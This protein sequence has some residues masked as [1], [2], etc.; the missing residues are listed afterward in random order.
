MTSEWKKLW[1]EQPTMTIPINGFHEVN[2]YYLDWALK[3]L[4]EGDKLDQQVN[5][6]ASSFIKSEEARLKAVNDLE[7]IKTGLREL[8]EYNYMDLCRTDV[9]RLIESES[10][11]AFRAAKEQAEYTI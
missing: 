1:S 5:I 8:L 6:L 3:V 10:E 9:E 11:K 2:P 7:A 4:D